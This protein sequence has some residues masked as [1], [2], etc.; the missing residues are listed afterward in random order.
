LFHSVSEITA[1]PHPHV[2]VAYDSN[3]VRE[4]VERDDGTWLE[5]GR[6]RIII[7]PRY[8]VHLSGDGLRTW[9]PDS[10]GFA[11]YTRPDTNSAFSPAGLIGGTNGIGDL[12]L[13]DDCGAIY[14]ST[15][16]NVW[17]APRT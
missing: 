10:T 1:G 4:L 3:D 8:G 7:A 2:L 12:Y 11:L 9:I 5:V 17:A 15:L 6:D 16:E 14:F 13:A